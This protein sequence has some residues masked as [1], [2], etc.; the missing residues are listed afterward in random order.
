MNPVFTPH[1]IQRTLN[2]VDV[3]SKTKLNQFYHKE[4]AFRTLNISS[5]Y[6]DLAELTHF[7]NLLPGGLIG[8]LLPRVLLKEKG[9]TYDAGTFGITFSGKPY[10]VCPVLEHLRPILTIHRSFKA[11]CQQVHKS[12]WGTTSLMITASSLWSSPAAMIYTP[13]Y[14]H[15]DWVLTSC[16]FNYPEETRS[17]VL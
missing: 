17:R 5:C 4:D 6:P 9:I 8:R 11:R 13:T 7:R 14:Q 12:P 1:L 3:Q 2:L 16:A 10:I 15:I